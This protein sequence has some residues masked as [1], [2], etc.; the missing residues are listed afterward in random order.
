[1]PFLIRDQGQEWDIAGHL[2]DPHSFLSSMTLCRS[3]MVPRP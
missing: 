3:C 1:M 2:S